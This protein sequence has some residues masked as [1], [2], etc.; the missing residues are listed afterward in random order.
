MIVNLHNSNKSKKVRFFINRIF[1]ARVSIFTEKEFLIR[2]GLL[3]G[4]SE[5]GKRDN[6]L[7]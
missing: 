5:F 1:S 2:L 6:Q 4:A 3:I 7:D